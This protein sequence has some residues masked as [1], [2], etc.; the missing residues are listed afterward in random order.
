MN[1]RKDM[2][3]KAATNTNIDIDS[4]KMHNHHLNK[5]GGSET[6]INEN[7]K[8]PSF[9]NIQES[10]GLNSNNDELKLTFNIF[11]KLEIIKKLNFHFGAFIK[12]LGSKVV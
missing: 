1:Q 11:P 12:P 6:S 7:T 4:N 9:E 8:I 2:L 3:R 10:N 5:I